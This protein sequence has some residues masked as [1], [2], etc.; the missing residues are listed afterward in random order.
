[1][2]AQPAGKLYFTYA[3]ERYRKYHDLVI[4]L[5]QVAFLTLYLELWSVCSVPV[6]ALRFNALRRHYKKD[7]SIGFLMAANL[8]LI[9]PN[10]SSV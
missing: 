4:H 10:F 2:R 8:F 3:P 9:K 6:R 1:L 5:T 7:Y